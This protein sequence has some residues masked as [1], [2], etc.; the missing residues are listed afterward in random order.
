M[1]FRKIKYW[2][3]LVVI[4]FVTLFFALFYYVLSVECFNN[5]LVTSNQKQRISFSEA[6]YYSF[7]T[8]TTLGCGDIIAK[9]F[10][11]FLTAIQ[12]AFGLIIAGIII[13]KITSKDS[14]RIS[15]IRKQATGYWLEPYIVTGEDIVNFSFTEIYYEDGAIMYRGENYDHNGKYNDYFI[16]NM[17]GDEGDVFLFRYK[18]PHKRNLFDSGLFELTFY[19]D[20]DKKK[21]IWAYHRSICYDHKKQNTTYIFGQRA[22]KDQVEAF[23]SNNCEEKARIIRSCIETFEKNTIINS[24]DN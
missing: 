22:T 2:Q 7:M 10:S 12:V 13:A 1:Y 21:G 11:R 19:Y 4:I 14:W 8:E 16:S 24:G 15:Y 20:N 5:G 17:I 23:L 3:L 18:N 9:G 6:L